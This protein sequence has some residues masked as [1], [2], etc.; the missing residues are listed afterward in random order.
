MW[1]S[2]GYIQALVFFG[3]IGTAVGGGIGLYV[4]LPKRLK[5]LR[6]P[7]VSLLAGLGGAPGIAT[8]AAFKD[9]RA[10]VQGLPGLYQGLPD[11]HRHP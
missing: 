4:A 8:A 3:C 6:A 11:G 1:Q 2:S 7:A 10:F 5:T 9:N